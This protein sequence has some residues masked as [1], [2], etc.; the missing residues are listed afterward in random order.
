MAPAD[1]VPE[2][3]GDADVTHQP[4]DALDVQVD[5]ERSLLRSIVVGAIVGMVVCAGIWA[6]IVLVAL[7]G[8]DW[9]LGPPVAMGAAV[10]VFAGAFYG[11][12]VGTMIGNRAVEQAEH[13]ALP[14]LEGP[15]D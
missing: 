3:R 6:L 7:A 1:A 15:G 8:S 12:W 9:S 2:V 11:G 13:H 5:A 10:G 4:E 14:E